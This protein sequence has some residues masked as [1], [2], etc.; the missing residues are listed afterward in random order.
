MTVHRNKFL[1][2]KTKQMNQFHKFTPAWNSTCFGQL[3]CPSSGIYSLYTRHWYMS[4]RF[5]ESFRTGP[6]C[7]GNWCICL[8]LL[9]RNMYTYIHTQLGEQKLLCET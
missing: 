9:Q 1:Y 6:G 8:V 5:E 3:L 2:N 4:Y 7:L